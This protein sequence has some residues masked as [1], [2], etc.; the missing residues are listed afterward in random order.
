MIYVSLSLRYQRQLNLICPDVLESFYKEAAAAAEAN[1]A[2]VIPQ[3]SGGL[4]A[5]DHRDLCCAFSVFL[6]LE[7]IL[8]LANE[9]K[10]RIRE[11]S[12]FVDSSEKELTPDEISDRIAACGN[13][14]L[15]DRAIALTREAADI[16]S[17]F[18]AFESVEGSGL[19]LFGK[20]RPIPSVESASASFLSRPILLPFPGSRDRGR[21][22]LLMA[23]LNTASILALDFDAM[24]FLT[25][26]ETAVFVEDKKAVGR[27]AATRFAL[28]HPVYILEAAEDYLKLFFMAIS[29]FYAESRGSEAVEIEVG[30]GL[31]PSGE[32]ARFQELLSETCVFNV[33][34]KDIFRRRDTVKADAIPPDMMDAAYL[35]Y[36]ASSFLLAGERDSLLGF[37]GKGRSFREAMDLR[38]SAAGFPRGADFFGCVQRLAA[39][40]FP[41]ESER[42]RLDKYLFD[43]LLDQGRSGLLST[44]MDFYTRLSALKISA[45]DS[46]LATAA[47]RSPSPA[48]VSEELKESFSNP[49]VAAAIKDLAEAEKKLNSGDYFNAQSDAK[50]VLQVFQRA[51]IPSGEFETFSFLARVTFSK[52]GASFDDAFSY[53]N[54]ALEGS[55][56]M[57]DSSA[58]MRALF[59]LA[60]MQFLSGDYF[61][62]QGTVRQLRESADER[63]DKGWVFAACFLEGMIYF[64]LG[65]YITCEKIFSALEGAC[66]SLGLQK[67]Q[68]LSSAW[69]FRAKAYMARKAAVAEYRAELRKGAPEAALFALESLAKAALEGESD[70]EAE[71][72]FRSLPAQ[73]ESVP[74]EGSYVPP[75]AWSWKSSFA[76][77]DDRYF[78]GLA[79]GAAST[80][81]SAFHA[82]CSGLYGGG[83]DA[84]AS[85]RDS[86]ASLVRSKLPANVPRAYIFYCLCYELESRVTGKNSAEALSFLSRAFKGAQT[87]ANNIGDASMREKFLTKPYWNAKLYTAA[88]ENNL[89]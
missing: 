12:V 30:D 63:Y 20:A 36:R 67:A 2:A 86:I 11:Y 65:D 38:L 75:D 46:L 44:S 85:S 62:A 9:R 72:L 15:P 40:G 56:K 83:K 74:Q 5:F 22:S 54:Y 1:G 28:T 39:K 26:K 53:L 50:R 14:V 45:P 42:K 24:G 89:I 21:C 49:A 43:Y 70:R 17:P 57:Q 41:A 88:R 78:C 6:T 32:L 51:K 16:L 7:A 87:L 52:S 77:E 79:S 81:Y 35:Y 55:V 29:R 10:E 76:F 64:S 84:L 3:G 68:P 8:Q 18:A 33:Q 82:F 71:S 13:I 4:Y 23:F 47:Y 59:D 61:Q 73:I 27:V 34:K 80:L 60:S 48:A 37:L 19:A 31:F 58:R 69:I 25:K 66:E